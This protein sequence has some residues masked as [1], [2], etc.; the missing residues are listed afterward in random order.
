VPRIEEGRAVLRL[1]IEGILREIVFAGAAFT[2]RRRVKPT[3]A[4]FLDAALD[5]SDEEAFAAFSGEN[6]GAR[7][8]PFHQILKRFEHQPVFGILGGVTIEAMLAED[9]IYRV[10]IGIGSQ[11]GA[12]E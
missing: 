8:A 6:R 1:Q 9:E 3:L 4:A 7:F 11:N 12:R 5:H 2:T 10:V